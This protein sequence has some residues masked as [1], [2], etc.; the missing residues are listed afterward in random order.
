[1]ITSTKKRP[2]MHSTAAAAMLLGLSEIRVRQLCQKG[3]LGE[4][5]GRNWV[6]YGSE[7]D[8]FKQLDRPPGRPAKKF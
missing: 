7:I 5:V 8:D 2:Q 6:I 1:M 4:K 3:K